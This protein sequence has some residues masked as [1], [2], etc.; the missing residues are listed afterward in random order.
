MRY[1]GSFYRFNLDTGERMKLIDK[2]DSVFIGNS[3]EFIYFALEK[4]LYR[5]CR[6]ESDLFKL[7]EYDED[8]ITQVMEY[9]E[10]I[11]YEAK[12]GLEE[13]IWKHYRVR[14]DGTRRERITD[15]ID[16]NYYALHGEWI[17]YSMGTEIYRMKLDGTQKIKVYE[18]DDSIISVVGV[19]D[20]GIYFTEHIE[21]SGLPPFMVYNKWKFD[22][23]KKV[24]IY[25]QYE[26]Y[27]ELKAKGL[28]RGMH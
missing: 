12:S 23:G 28:V 18:N 7:L 27:R 16:V 10:W 9:G 19:T 11:Y 25:N 6:D 20:D 13:P 21:V 5:I 22:S 8:H 1:D 15:D 14:Q 24:Q 4:Q 26:F 2:Y 17:Y 3:N